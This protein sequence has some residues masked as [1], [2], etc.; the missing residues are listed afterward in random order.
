MTSL[1]RH[2]FDPESISHYPMPDETSHP[3]DRPEGDAESALESAACVL[4][5]TPRPGGTSALGG[6]E[7]FRRRQE[8][9]L[10]AW[11]EKTGRL[12][13]AE[14]YLPHLRAGGEEHRIATPGDRSRY[15]KVTN[16][17]R[18]GFTVVAGEETGNV[19]EL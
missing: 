6:R 11:A 16:P 5:G 19:P 13:S 12:I 7:V 4:G 10:L 18:C 17:G 1:S 9:D 14:T 3:P 8:R 2:M 15:W